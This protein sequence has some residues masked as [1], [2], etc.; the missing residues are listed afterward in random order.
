M[1][2]LEDRKWGE[3]A[4]Q[5]IGVACVAAVLSAIWPGWS[6]LWALLTLDGTPAWVQA[7][8]SIGTI[9]GGVWAVH[10]QL[11]EQRRD[12]SERAA[13]EERKRIHRCYHFML[14]PVIAVSLI[15]EKIVFIA[16][17]ERPNWGQLEDNADLVAK[18][19]EVVS[20]SDLPVPAAGLM[21]VA[22]KVS[23]SSI[24]L[25]SRLYKSLPMV[26]VEH[27]EEI[28][29]VAKELHEAAERGISWINKEISAVATDAEKDQHANAFASFQ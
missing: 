29:H 22:L 2:R 25:Q 5:G 14:G 23:A 26:G 18:T 1:S 10:H 4:A 16:A 11:M 15:A 21:L 6:R 12:A 17:Q 24:S 3:R 13:E 28:R 19:L 20:A 7:V 8:G 9:A 27:I